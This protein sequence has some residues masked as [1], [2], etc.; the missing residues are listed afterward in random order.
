MDHAVTIRN[1]DTCVRMKGKDTLVKEVDLFIGYVIVVKGKSVELRP[2]F[3]TVVWA[4]VMAW[5]LKYVSQVGHLGYNGMWTYRHRPA[6][7]T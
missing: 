4:V 2:P 1:S 6:S 7:Q 5:L 3:H